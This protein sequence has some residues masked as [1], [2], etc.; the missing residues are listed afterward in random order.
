MAQGS[1]KTTPRDFFL[2]L[3]SII[4]LYMSAVGLTTLLFQY[5]NH[6]YPDPLEYVSANVGSVRFAIAALVILF[7]VY[8]LTTLYMHKGYQKN[9]ASKDVSVRKW[10]VY[11]T[12]FAAALIIIGDFVTLV[13]KF[14]EGEL[15]ARFFLKVI[16]ILFV[17]GMIFWYYFWDLR[18][19]KDRKPAKNLAYA[20]SGLILLVIIASFAV[21]GTPGEQRMKLFDDRRVGD[22]QYLQ[23]EI[24]TYWQ[25]KDRLPDELA[26]LEDPLRGTS[27]PADPETGENYVYNIT[28]DESFE[29]CATFSAVSDTT[30]RANYYPYGSES[31]N[32]GAGRVCFERTIDPDFYKNL[33]NPKPL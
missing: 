14:L 25:G 11:F 32:H 18:G 33:E 6:L 30:T 27:I 8:I 24:V 4:G 29:L 22:L 3:L 10:M 21:I 20:V 31:W 16:A 7:P 23:S 28:G 9:P 5:I 17:A 19:P 2:N 1:G 12:L 13:M 15:T 26:E